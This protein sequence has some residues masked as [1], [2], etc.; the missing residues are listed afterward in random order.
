MPR[1]RPA[2]S[3]ISAPLSRSNS[4]AWSGTTPM[5]ALAARGP[6]AH[7][8][9]P[10]I[11]IWPTSGRSR[12]VII[13]RDVVFPAPFGPTSPASEPAAISRSIPATASLAP[14]L[15]HSPRT[16]TAGSLMSASFTLA[17]CGTAAGLGWCPGLS[18]T[19]FACSSTM[20]PAGRP[21]SGGSSA[22]SVSTG[23]SMASGGLAGWACSLRSGWGACSGA[24]RWGRNRVRAV[25][26][27]RIFDAIFS[28]V[29]SGAD[30]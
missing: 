4:R 13:D 11:W 22:I 29:G 17:S 12:R 27:A 9:S 7:T 15:L 1:S 18:G 30:G 19:G 20:L 21:V 26:K 5:A 8:S 23:E 2:Y 25:T 10:L 28:A 6:S 14:K 16:T 24:G 3:S